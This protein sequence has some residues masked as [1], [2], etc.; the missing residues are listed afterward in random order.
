MRLSIIYNLTKKIKG[1]C[2]GMQILSELI[3]KKKLKIN[4]LIEILIQLI[5]NEKNVSHVWNDIQ[6]FKMII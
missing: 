5:S 4:I 3:I 1:I 6:L 2:I